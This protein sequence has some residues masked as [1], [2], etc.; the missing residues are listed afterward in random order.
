L[1]LPKFW[2]WIHL[3]LI[4]SSIPYYWRL[5]AFYWFYFGSLGAFLPYWGLYLQAQ[6]FNSMAIGELLAIIS[7]TKIIAPNIWGWLADHT[8]RS[9]LLMRLGSLLS[10]ICFAGFLFG[11]SYLWLVIISIV[12][13]FFWNAILPL[14]EASTFAMLGSQSYRYGQIRL[15]GSA[16]FIVAVILFGELFAQ[17]SITLLPLFLLIPFASIFLMSLLMPEVRTTAISPPSESFYQVLK[18]PAVIALFLVCLLMQASHGPYYT[19]YTVYLEGYGYSRSLIGQLWALG[20]IA[21]IGI[22]LVMHYLLAWINLT[23]L[24]LISLGLTGGRWLLIGYYPEFLSVLVFAQLL[25]AVSFGMYHGVVM[26][27]IRERFVNHYQG[28]AQAL[29]SSLSFGV[30]GALGSLLSGY[31][32]ENFTP[33][34]SYGWA[35]AVCGLAMGICW[36]WIK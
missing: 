26:Q 33:M 25:H 14:I 3:K 20:V 10:V 5:S 24:L 6:G 21:E 16:G 17:V 31:T 36:R 2:L 15:W 29:Y 1:T 18:Q 30:G 35:A 28:K 7:V 32:W 9:V 13:S 4:M 11:K 23:T 12:F 27:L 19:F 8:G 34:V 22:F